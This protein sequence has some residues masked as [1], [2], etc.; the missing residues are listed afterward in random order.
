M[1][2]ARRLQAI[3]PNTPVTASGSTGPMRNPATSGNP[4]IVAVLSSPNAPTGTTPSITVV[5]KGSI[6]GSTFYVLYT[7]TAI[8]AAQAIPQR[9][10]IQNALEPWLQ[11]DWTVSGT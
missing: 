1:A 4:N 5:V 2:Q 11:V 6:D 7:F 3:A 10:V 8:T 9:Q